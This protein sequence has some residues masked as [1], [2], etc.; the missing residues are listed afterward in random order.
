MA[1]ASAQAQGH[2]ELISDDPRCESP[3]AGVYLEWKRFRELSKEYGGLLTT[4]QAAKLLDVTTSYLSTMISRGRFTRFTVLGSS[5]I[6]APE[7]ILFAKQRAEGS[8]RAGGRANQSVSLGDLVNQGF[9][10]NVERI[11]SLR[12]YVFTP[13]AHFALSF[14]HACQ[15]RPI[16]TPEGSQGTSGLS[17]FRPPRRP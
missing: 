16:G 17:R 6:P 14:F 11:D 13:A 2:P 10:D 1:T 8:F 5:M 3:V 4:G 9:A 15:T 7:I 12:T